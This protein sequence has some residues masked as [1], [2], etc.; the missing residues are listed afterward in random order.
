MQRIGLTIALMLSVVIVVRGQSP[1]STAE[2]EVRDA[3]LRHARGFETGDLQLI[4]SVWSHSPDVTVFEN[5]RA[6]HGWE[7]FRDHHL[8]ME[9]GAMK[10][11]KYT[12]SDMKTRVS[13]D[14]ACT[15]FTYAISADANDHHVDR[16]GIGTAVLEKHTDGWKIVHWHTSSPRKPAADK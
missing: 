11:V 1:A 7:D 3:L 12:Y 9:L 4:E 5:G 10:N 15:T 13:G 6:N 16:G 8:K 2:T 14:L